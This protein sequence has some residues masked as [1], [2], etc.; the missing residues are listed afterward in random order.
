MAPNTRAD[1]SRRVPSSTVGGMKDRR[2]LALCLALLAAAC[3]SSGQT[4]AHPAPRAARGGRHLVRPIGVDPCPGRG[5]GRDA[6]RWLPPGD[7]DRFLP[8]VCRHPCL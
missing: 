7:T 1:L 6:E 2:V 4:A 3:T 8:P 5:A